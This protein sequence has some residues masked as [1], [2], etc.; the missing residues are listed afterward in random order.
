MSP[1]RPPSP[2]S[3]P[4]M[5]TNFSRRNETMPDPPSPAFTL[6]T[7]RSMNMPSLPP[8][9]RPEQ[10]RPARPLLPD[11]IRDRVKRLIDR[12]RFHADV[13]CAVQMRVELPLLA[14]RRARG[15]DAQLAPREV[16]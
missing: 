15:H 10:P 16:E 12:R 8:N 2:P 4:P 14:R 9:S 6:T 5:G 1:P 3:G 7:T 11:E 13:E